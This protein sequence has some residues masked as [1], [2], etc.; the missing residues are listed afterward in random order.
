MV[1]GEKRVP[2]S[3]YAGELENVSDN[4][5]WADGWD[6]DNLRSTLYPVES[7]GMEPTAVGPGYQLHHKLHYQFGSAHS[8]G[9]N[10]L[11]GDGAVHFI[12]YDIDRENFNRYGHRHD[13][14][15]ITAEL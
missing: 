7:D 9:M 14:E 1:A 4:R 15:V 2:P 3:T 10:A 11:F 12:S 6:Y 13:G 5:G 8:G